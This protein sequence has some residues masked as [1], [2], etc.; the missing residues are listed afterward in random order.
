MSGLCG[1]PLSFKE[2]QNYFGY[3]GTASNLMSYHRGGAYVPNVPQNSNIPTTGTIKISNFLGA[4]YWPIDPTQIV[5]NIPVFSFTIDSGTG[6]DH[7]SS[8]YLNQ[9]QVTNPF[10]VVYGRYNT[11]NGVSDTSLTSGSVAGGSSGVVS[12]S[13]P[14]GTIIRFQQFI[15]QYCISGTSTG[16]T[17]A[18]AW[19]QHEPQGT[20]GLWFAWNVSIVPG[21]NDISTS[22]L[23]WVSGTGD[24][25]LA[26][27][28]TSGGS[29]FVAAA[30]QLI[31]QYATVSGGAQN[32]LLAKLNSY[33]WTSSNISSNF[34][35]FASW[36]ESAYNCGFNILGLTSTPSSILQ[37]GQSYSQ[38]NTASG[39]TTPYIYSISTG[40]TPVGTSL[41][42]STGLVSG[43][44]TTATSFSYTVKVT[45]SGSP[46]QNASQTLSGT[47][48][49]AGGGGGG[50]GGCIWTNSYLHNGNKINEVTVGDEILILNDTAD[51][52]YK[53]VVKHSR[54]STQPCAILK[55]ETGIELTLSYTTPI[56]TREGNNTKAIEV[57]QALGKEVPVLDHGEFKWEKIVSITPVGELPVKL[58]TGGNGTYAAGNTKDRLIFTHTTDSVKYGGA[59][60]N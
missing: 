45:D 40:T 49:A 28:I 17:F 9:S 25:R 55:T 11:S 20:G 50:G 53:H 24:S 6:S 7:V 34:T 31:L 43:T 39:G 60:K 23:T 51:G 32:A 56:I 22:Q 5:S 13:S 29:G 1:F 44:P 16:V 54:V 19:V 27:P 41:N 42:T 37:V 48:L 14:L 52:H 18:P 30:I 10:Y 46:V 47:I 35:D 38:V 36:A 21:G 59:S 2:I 8:W 33:T 3:W 58:I 26:L 15:S 12:S 57:S 4:S